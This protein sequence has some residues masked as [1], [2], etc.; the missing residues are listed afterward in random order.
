MRC[1]TLDEL[2]PPP[3]G[4][5]G[6]PWT[7]E[8]EQLPDTM[9]VLSEAEG[10]DDRPR[11]IDDNDSSFVHRPSS[12]AS[13][14][15]WPRISI[16]TPSYN[17][18]QF[19]EETIRSVLLQGYPNLEYIIIDGG[20][21]DGSVEII[22]RYEPW[23]T[24]WVSEPDGGQTEAL[25]KGFS[26]ATGEVVAWLNSDD[27]YEPNALAEAIRYFV[28]SPE[29]GLVYGDCTAV[30]VEGEI[31][32][33]FKPGYL[34]LTDLVLH[35]GFI[36][37]QSAFFKRE[38]LEQVGGLDASLHYVMD[39]HLWV[40]L[41]NNVSTRYVHSIWANYRMHIDSKSVAQR[42]GFGLEVA[43]VLKEIS[44]QLQVEPP[45]VREGIR[46]AYL[47]ASLELIR[48]GD[49]PSAISYLEKALESFEYPYGSL[50]SCVNYSLGF[51]HS[52]APWASLAYPSVNVA[53]SHLID[54]AISQR[55]ARSVLTYGYTL[56]AYHAYRCEDFSTARKASRSA[57]EMDTN[58]RRND[59]CVELWIKA[60]IGHHGIMAWRRFCSYFRGI[61]EQ[62]E[63][64]R[65]S[66]I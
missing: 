17:Q 9:S 2:P 44:D 65:V 23:L 39:Y 29:M 14:R 32:R 4:K 1:P 53:I 62:M 42:S 54:A 37:Q 3:A 25:A 47:W 59:G 58:V 11:T 49:C 43:N 51:L 16:V 24:Y 13:S 12:D 40:R 35:N 31:L 7:E 36:P 66:T 18:G 63:M 55:A 6:W 57:L 22:R 61:L 28:Q 20:S 50:E 64:D 48:S 26:Q 52:K 41:V 56:Q 34:S 15:A 27:F 30:S 8:S 38:S 5:T 45:V 60:G 10:P 19:I 33:Q 21:D 46:R